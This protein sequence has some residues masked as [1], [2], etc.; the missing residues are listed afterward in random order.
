ML[1]EFIDRELDPETMG[2]IREHL[3]VCRACRRFTESL[4]KT[5]RILR[6]DPSYPMPEKAAQELM[7]TLRKEYRRSQR[8]LD[9][10]DS[11]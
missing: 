7:T 1:S 9:D 6:S 3:Q 4:E 5:S 8:E 2:K 10:L 11:E